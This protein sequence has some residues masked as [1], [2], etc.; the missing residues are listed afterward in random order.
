MIGRT[1]KRLLP[2]RL[3]GR[4][5]MIIITPLVVMQLISGYVFYAQ[6]WDT[7]SW[8]LSVNVA[9]DVSLATDAVLRADN[10]RERDEQLALI[11][12]T[13]GRS[14]RFLEGAMIEGP[15]V[16]GNGSV[17]QKLDEAMRSAALAPYA[18]IDPGDPRPVTIEVQLD[19]GMLEVRVPRKHLFSDSTYLFWFWQ[20][21]SSMLLAVIAILFMRNQVRPIRRLASVAERFGKGLEVPAFKPEGA[22]EV[23]RAGIEFNRMR[24]RI[25]RQ[26]AQRTEMLAGVSHDLR[27]PLTRLKL[28]LALLP[29]NPAHDGMRGDI[30]EM[31]RLIDSYLT[32]L[33]GEDGETAEEADVAALVGDVVQRARIDGGRP[34]ETAIE[35][36]LFGQLRPIALRRS[37]SNLISNA[38]RY[39]ARV[40]VTA[41]RADELIELIVEDD[42]PGI[43][44][45]RYE[46]AFKPFFRL[47]QSR[48][49]R[50]GGIGLG[51]AIARDLVR[52]Q[53]GEITL[54]VSPL[55]GLRAT[56]RLP[57]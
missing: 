28:Q 29:E 23:R 15:R 37:L 49:A 47:D 21:G 52:A 36:P 25:L 20:I 19:D 24:D 57:A 3:M 40:L 34:I 51:L 2:K 31:E 54:D 7:L 44:P 17:A 18:V 12:A 9:W 14:T 1:I 10:A 16:R 50:T 33:R 6:L 55:G 46:D 27:T 38:C 30:E 56:I 45:A 53:G 13:T 41:R 22:T 8:R 42:G 35:R 26:I 4:A 5:L 39:G 32:Y 11:A 43:P 48:N